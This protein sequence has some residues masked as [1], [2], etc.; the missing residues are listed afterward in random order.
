MG[1]ITI[2]MLNNNIDVA[3]FLTKNESPVPIPY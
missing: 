3:E 1:S 2:L